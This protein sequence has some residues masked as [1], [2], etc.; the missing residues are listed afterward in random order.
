[1]GRVGQNRQLERRL[2]QPLT[3]GVVQSTYSYFS[4]SSFS[5]HFL[6]NL[7]VEY[8]LFSLSEQSSRWYHVNYFRELRILLE[9]SGIIV[10]YIKINALLRLFYNY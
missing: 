5:F 4:F 6:K 1:M 7:V 10:Q 3:R 2:N 8:P 9:A